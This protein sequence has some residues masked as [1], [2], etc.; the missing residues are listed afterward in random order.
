MRGLFRRR[1]GAPG[2]TKIGRA[3][4]VMASPDGLGRRSWPWPNHDDGHA[5]TADADADGSA[6]PLPLPLPYPP[7]RM[8]ARVTRCLLA[9]RTRSPRRTPPPWPRPAH[10][11]ARLHLHH[12]HHPP[13]RL[14]V[15]P[16]R[17]PHALCCSAA[18]AAADRCRPNMGGPWSQ[19][20]AGHGMRNRYAPS[21]A[22]ARATGPGSQ[23]PPWF[24][25][26]RAIC[27]PQY[28]HR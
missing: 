23:I 10:A 24:F 2:G 22:L 7:R 11:H 5:A 15:F 6:L 13:V 28:C 12:H 9:A 17:Q 25:K 1:C 3:N 26:R 8:T 27:C 14:F 19:T 4:P 21:P 16:A 20:W 18:A